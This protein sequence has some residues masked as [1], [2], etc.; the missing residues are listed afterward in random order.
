VIVF[1]ASKPD[2]SLG[3]E[4]AS[5][6]HLGKPVIV[7]YRANTGAVPHGLKGIN[8]DKLQVDSYD[9]ETLPELLKVAIDY[10]QDV[11]DIRFNFFISPSL[12]NYLDWISQ[13]KKCPALYTCEKLIERDMEKNKEYRDS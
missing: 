1:E 9:E 8:S 11:S 12:S 10:A 6:L 2:V 4:V 13:T 5:A 3:Y 7:L